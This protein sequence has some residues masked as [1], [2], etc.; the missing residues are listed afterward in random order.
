MAGQERW[1]DRMYSGAGSGQRRRQGDPWFRTGD[2]GLVLSLTKS[3][4]QTR[5]RQFGAELRH[6]EESMYLIFCDWSCSL[7]GTASQKMLVR[8]LQCE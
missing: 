1:G 7:G 2:L 3:G 8:S 4:T 6:F 5:S